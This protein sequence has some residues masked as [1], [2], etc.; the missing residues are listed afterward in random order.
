MLMWWRLCGLGLLGAILIFAIIAP[1]MAISVKI[2]MPGMPPSAHQAETIVMLLVYAI[3]A[4]LVGA[5]L[6]VGVVLARRI[7]RRHRTSN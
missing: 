1:S 4:T 6:L 7:I 3:Q 5:V 2:E